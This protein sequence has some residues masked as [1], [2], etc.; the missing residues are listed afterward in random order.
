[1]LQADYIQR[2]IFDHILA[3]LMPSNRLAIEVSLATG[4]RIGDVLNIRSDKLA[5]R[6]SVREAKTG[7]I[8]RITLSTSLLDALIAQSGR[9]FVFEHRLDY[10]K[11]RTRQ[12]VYKD[13]KRAC[14]A[15]RLPKTLQVSPH[16]ARKIYAVN[17][18]QTSYSLDKVKQL[19]NH[20]DEAVTMLYAMADTITERRQHRKR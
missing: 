7:K 17:K 4:L 6:M 15:Y 19:L 11:H 3:V 13:I 16:S 8:K 9:L 1:M 10:R 20:S 12:A 5:K 14:V 2:D 18:Y